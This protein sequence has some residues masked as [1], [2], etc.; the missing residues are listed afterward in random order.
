M[1]HKTC[2][3]IG[4]RKIDESEE[5]KQRLI[6]VIEDLIVNHNVFTFLFGSRSEFNDLCHEIVTNLKKNTHV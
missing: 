3:F 1:E 6:N 4:H 5:L 2:S